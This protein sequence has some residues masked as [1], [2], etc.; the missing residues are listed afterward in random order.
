MSAG[1]WNRF[2][3]AE[4]QEELA[5][6][7]TYLRRAQNAIDLEAAGRFKQRQEMRLTG[8]SA[9]PIP[10]QPEGSPYADNPVPPGD[11]IDKLGFDINEVEPVIPERP[12]LDAPD[13][14]SDI[15]A[16]AVERGEGQGGESAPTAL[17]PLSSQPSPRKR[18]RRF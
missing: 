14:G 12:T 1:Y 6:D 10:R 8:Q 17:T 7:D 5:H 13:N 11:A 15:T 9:D 4:K 16:V 3:Q 18:W 2:T